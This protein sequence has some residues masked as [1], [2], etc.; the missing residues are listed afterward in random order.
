LFDFWAIILNSASYSIPVFLLAYYFTPAVVGFYALGARVLAIPGNLVS[1]AVYQAFFQ[2]AVE[3]H[4]SGELAGI[5]LKVFSRLLNISFVPLA[6]ITIVAPDLFAV[7]FGVHWT[8]AGEYL[9]WLSLAIFFKFICSPISSIYN[10][11]EQQNK[12]LLFN[13]ML[14][15]ARTSGLIIGGMHRDPLL[16][17][18]LFGLGSAVM[19][20]YLNLNI[21]Y[22]AGLSIWKVLKALGSELLASIPYIALPIG[23]VFL[24][25]SAIFF[26][27]SAVF[28]GLVFAVVLLHRFS[29]TD[30][31]ESSLLNKDNK[32]ITGGK[33]H[34]Q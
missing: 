7:I 2:Q 3:T 27:I 9:R 17:I 22:M 14:L 31:G 30:S 20:F 33:S 28:S 11:L 1:Q 8:I 29:R 24:S 10:V 13:I 21:M 23:V 34:D 19:L 15:I 5:T 32:T 26:V 12:Y 18:K 16:A 25:H 4:R 6:L